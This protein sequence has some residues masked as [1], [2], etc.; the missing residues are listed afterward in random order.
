MFQRILTFFIVLLSVCSAVLGADERFEFE[1]THMGM[2]VR[3]ILYAPTSE[4]AGKAASDAF[5]SFKTL[6]DIMSDYDSDSELSLLCT[7]NG[8]EK[9]S[10]DLF[11]V[12]KASKH[13]CTFSDG[14]FDITV[15]PMVRLW[16]RS[17]RQHELPKEEYIK[18]AKELVG[19]HLWE[20]DE[21]TRS[22]RL[23]KTG[24]K[25]DLGAIAKG[26]A[27]D[28]AFDI[29]QKHGISSQLVDAGGDFRLGS[30]PPGT[31]GWK[32]S[33]SG[34]TVLLKNIAMATSGGQFQFVEIEGVR[35]A[36]I[37]DPKTGIGM[38]GLQTVHVTAPTAMEAD[39][40]ATA[41]SVLG[42]EKG[43]VL[44]VKLPN[45]AVKIATPSTTP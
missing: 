21:C 40:L 9:V 36:H 30:A 16:R 13:Y 43:M 22:V 12:L 27:I 42:K 25:L 45:V 29:I 34:E 3:I 8:S 1:E 6:N 7:N 24:M 4:L 18:Q 23:L 31:E 11:A 32:I 37:V 26:Y 10:D 35:Y 20:L 14:A 17:R 2:P 39:A 38:T 19:N 33:Q 28:K 5:A 44:I 15:G 41:V